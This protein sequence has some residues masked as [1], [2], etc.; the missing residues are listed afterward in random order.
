VHVRFHPYGAKRTARRSPA[1]GWH[2]E[3][4]GSHFGRERDDAQAV[5]FAGD[6]TGKCWWETSAI[7]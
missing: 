2:I 7:I 6:G 5:D 4:K 1:L 3:P